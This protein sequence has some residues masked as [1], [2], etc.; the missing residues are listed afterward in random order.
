VLYRITDDAELVALPR[1][2]DGEGFVH[3][4]YEHQVRTAADE[5][6]RGRTDLLLATVDPDRLVGEIR[7]ENGF[8][9]LYGTLDRDA[10]VEV[11]P[12]T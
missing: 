6:Y 4:S 2:D 11:V 12:F 7:I 9:H 3:L 1:S 10:I 5:H 8:P